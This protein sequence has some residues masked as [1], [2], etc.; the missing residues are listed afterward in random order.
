VKA[1]AKNEDS[2]KEPTFD[3]TAIERVNEFEPGV[4]PRVRH[5]CPS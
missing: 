3:R 1:A 2:G 5:I 4:F